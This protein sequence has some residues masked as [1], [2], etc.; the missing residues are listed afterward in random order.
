M[1]SPDDGSPQLRALLVAVNEYDA[2]SVP[3]L[4]GCENDILAI[5]NLLTNRFG[6]HPDNICKRINSEA[7]RD[8]IITAFRSH[9]I[10]HAE[11]SGQAAEASQPGYLYYFS[12][13]GSQAGTLRAT[14]DPP[15]RDHRPERQPH[16][17]GA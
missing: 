16:Q 13:H 3:D 5:E 6:V 8:G 9:L 10:G 2:D 14:E 12:G 7:T 1:S 4:A 11:S 17:W 15:R